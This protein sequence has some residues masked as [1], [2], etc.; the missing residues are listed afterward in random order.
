MELRSGTTFFSLRRPPAVG[1]GRRILFFVDD[2]FLQ[3]FWG[4]D[5]LKRNRICE[6]SIAPAPLESSLV[7]T[8]VDAV[9]SGCGYAS[10][11]S[12]CEGYL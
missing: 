9:S 8:S 1:R 6:G 7:E 5:E 11:A 10:K 12:R 4:T 3:V 2:N